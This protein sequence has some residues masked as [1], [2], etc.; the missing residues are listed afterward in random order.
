[1]KY[2]SVTPYS[3]L[4]FGQMYPRPYNAGGTALL[5][6]PTLHLHSL[7]LRQRSYHVAWVAM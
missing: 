5:Q 4:P 1:M 3:C 7:H 6:V 2:Y